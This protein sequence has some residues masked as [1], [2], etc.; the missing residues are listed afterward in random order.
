MEGRI[1]D[2]VFACILCGDHEKGKKYAQKLC[3]WLEK[4]KRDGKSTYYNREKG[5][6]QIEFLAGYYTESDAALEE[7]LNREHS[8]EICH[9][10]TCPLCK[11]MEGARILWLLRKG[12]REEA[13][14]VLQRNLEIQPW[15]EYMLAI[16]H[17]AFQA[18]I[19]PY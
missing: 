5:H 11:E 17:V 14:K 2:T 16:K 6:L 4:E 3:Q 19:C 1:C 10:C 8:A 12:Q 13:G 9:F 15:D 18:S 7:I